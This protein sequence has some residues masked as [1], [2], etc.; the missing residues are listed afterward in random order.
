MKII[1]FFALIGT[2]FTASGCKDLQAAY[3]KTGA[4]A[5]NGANYTLS[6]DR[7]T[8]DLTDYFG[9]SWQLK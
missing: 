3:S 8:G 1:A 2:L 6:R 4:W 9:L 7:E 5:P